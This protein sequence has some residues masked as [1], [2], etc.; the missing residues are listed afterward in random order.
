[1]GEAKR[2]KAMGEMYGMG[3][4]PE[5]ARPFVLAMQEMVELEARTV[6]SEKKAGNNHQFFF[7]GALGAESGVYGIGIPAVLVDF[8]EYAF[9]APINALT[10]FTGATRFGMAMHLSDSKKNLHPAPDTERGS[11]IMLLACINGAWFYNMISSGEAG[12]ASMPGIGD[13][14][15]GKIEDLAVSEPLNRF[16]TT[17]VETLKKSRILQDNVKASMTLDYLKEHY[18]AAVSSH[19]QTHTGGTVSVN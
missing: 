13:W 9:T 19:T 18:R 8:D 3:K 6:S 16:M 4:L 1:M 12:V 14:Q 15:Q 11:A 2:R 10:G 17:I 7:D 5:A